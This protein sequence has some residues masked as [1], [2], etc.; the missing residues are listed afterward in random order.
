MKQMLLS[1]LG[2]AILKYLT[3]YDISIPTHEGKMVIIH[4]LIL[5]LCF[6]FS[7]IKIY[8]LEYFVTYLLHVHVSSRK[9]IWLIIN[10]SG[11][12]L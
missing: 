5:K 3:W 9:L 7:H 10:N 12:T 1:T 8:K 6:H 4:F 2:T 11:M